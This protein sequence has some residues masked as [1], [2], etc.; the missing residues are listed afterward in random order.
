MIAG[1]GIIRRR[2]VESRVESI[3]SDVFDSS[4]GSRAE[5]G[6]VASRSTDSR[7]HAFSRRRLPLSGLPV[8][9]SYTVVYGR[10]CRSRRRDR[11]MSTHA[12][13]RSFRHLIF[14]LSFFLC[15]LF[16][17]PIFSTS[18]PQELTLTDDTVLE[19]HYEDPRLLQI[20]LL[21]EGGC[22]DFSQQLN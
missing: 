2:L 19:E 6:G 10:H 3:A 16:F 20:K 15:R 14:F 13:S 1:L 7:H 17:S 5:V 8:R 12:P 4:E 9:R 18:H 21:G 11:G 22:Y